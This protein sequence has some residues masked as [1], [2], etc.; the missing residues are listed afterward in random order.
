VRSLLVTGFWQIAQIESMLMLD[1]LCPDSRALGQ[2]GEDLGKIK[3]PRG[4]GF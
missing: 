1:V 4:R 3:E 2:K